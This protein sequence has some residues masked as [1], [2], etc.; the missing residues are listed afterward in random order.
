[1]SNSS[2]SQTDDAD[3][4]KITDAKISQYF[5]YA[6]VRQRCLA[7]GNTERAAHI[8]KIMRE[9]DLPFIMEEE[10]EIPSIDGKHPNAQLLFDGFLKWISRN[11]DIDKGNS[12]SPSEDAH[13]PPLAEMISRLVTRPKHREWILGDRAEQFQAHVLSRGVRMA[14]AFYWIDTGKS[15]WPAV[16]GLVQWLIA[17][18]IIRRLMGS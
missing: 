18:D 11:G 10:E 16:K 12:T 2:D 3:Y 14:K 6:Q 1:M 7:E 9:I 17:G 13:P 5:D 8:L 4:V 15:C